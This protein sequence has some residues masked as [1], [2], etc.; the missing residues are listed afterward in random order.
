MNQ[1][2][3][4]AAHTDFPIDHDP[5]MTE[6]IRMAI[7]QIKSG[8]AARPDN[9]PAE[10]LKSDIQVTTNMHTQCTDAIATLRIIVEQSVEWNSSLYINF[11]DYEKAF[12][13]VHRR[14]LRKLLRH[15]VVPEK[16]VNIIR[17]SYDG[18]Q[19]K[20]VHGGQMTDAFQVKTADREG[21]LL[22]ALT[23]Y[24]ET[25]QDVAS[26]T[27]LGSIIDELGGSDADVKATIGKARAAFLQLKN[28]WNSKQLS[29]NQYK[30]Q[31]LQW[32]RQGSSTVRS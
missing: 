5:P 11:I 19:C 15:Y 7:R 31:N 4:E 3:I 30:S 13:S 18:L 20:V 32:Q 14:T 12:D 10:A 22:Y 26:F 21:C 23:L 9:I 6:E 8:K 25:L 2:D 16:I 28:V 24:G 27:Y 1:P 29:V 17:N